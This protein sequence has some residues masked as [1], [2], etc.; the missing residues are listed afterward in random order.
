MKM[1]KTAMF[2]GLILLQSTSHAETLCGKAVSLVLKASIRN[3]GTI[4]GAKF[5]TRVIH[6]TF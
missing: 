4:V 6:L 5:F 2:F 1:I 3:H